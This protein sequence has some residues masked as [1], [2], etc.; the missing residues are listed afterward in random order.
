MNNKK[1]IFI[2]GMCVMEGEY[3]P[4]S[5]ARYLKD[6]TSNYNVDFYFKISFDKANRSSLNSFRGLGLKKGVE[7][8]AKI[9]KEVGCKI[10]TDVHNVMQ[11]TIVKEV[12]DVIQIPAFLCRQTDLVIAVG[13]TG[14]IANIK[15]GQFLAPQDIKYIVEKI[16]STGN[17]NIMLT[18]RGTCF[19]YNDLVVDFRSFSILKKLSYPVIFD[20][21]H[22]LQSGKKDN[23]TGGNPEL[24]IPMARAGIAYG[25]D[26]LFLETHPNPKKAKSDK[27][28]SLNFEQIKQ[29]LESIK[30]TRK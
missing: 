22:S 10:L 5:V 13:R 27:Y 29:I 7:I 21:T 18:E 26:G 15:K 6:L 12:A 2:C 4:V 14:K 23:Q 24:A 17:K 19:G 8:L 1:F 20:V 16:E 28:T 11:A 9:K 30:E 3:L 25:V